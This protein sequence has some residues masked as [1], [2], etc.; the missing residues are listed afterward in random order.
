MDALKRLDLSD[1]LTQLVVAVVVI[2][3]CTLVAR[4]FDD[5][6]AE[7]GGAAAAAAPGSSA[8]AMQVCIEGLPDNPPRALAGALKAAL[9]L[10][11]TPVVVAC[12]PRAVVRL[13]TM[14]DYRRCSPPQTATVLVGGTRHWPHFLL[15]L[16]LAPRSR[17]ARRCP[18][19]VRAP[20]QLFSRAVCSV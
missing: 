15:R 14:D 13:A 19:P 1:S 7:S 2:A 4:L 11:A 20:A 12:G 8:G 5:P 9:G 10:S 16:W 6:K 17:A 18:A 3:S